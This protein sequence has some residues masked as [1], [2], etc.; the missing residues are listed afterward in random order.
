MSTIDANSNV[1]GLV[2]TDDASETIVP[3]LVDPISDEL[4]IEI[5]SIHTPTGILKNPKIDSNSVETASVIVDG[6]ETITSVLCTDEGY[7]IME[8]I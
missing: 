6:T 7:I 1:V 8:L 5:V 2:V 3:L 4:L